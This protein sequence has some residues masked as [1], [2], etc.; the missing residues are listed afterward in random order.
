MV[1]RKG[2]GRSSCGSSPTS[3]DIRGCDPD[4]VDLVGAEASAYVKGLD[5]DHLVTLGDG[6]FGLAGGWDGNG[7]YSIQFGRGLD[8]AVFHL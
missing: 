3:R 8:S 6:G 1:R 7:T 5:S 2:H 4:V